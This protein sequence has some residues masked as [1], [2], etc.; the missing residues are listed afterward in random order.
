VSCPCI[1][2][3]LSLITLNSISWLPEKQAQEDKKKKEET[4]FPDQSNPSS[5]AMAPDVSFFFSFTRQGS[6]QLPASF[7]FSSLYFFF[8]A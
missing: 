1:L 8:F 4:Y 7:F 5:I 6:S 3:G 2:K